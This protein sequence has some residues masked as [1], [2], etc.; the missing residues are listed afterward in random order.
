MWLVISPWACR[1]F[2]FLE[3]SCLREPRCFQPHSRMVQEKGVRQQ[4]K[5]LWVFHVAVQLDVHSVG[6]VI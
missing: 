2:A 6:A 3:A 5:D 1:Q 4:L